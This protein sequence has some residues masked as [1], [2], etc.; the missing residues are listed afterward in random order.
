MIK[1]PKI[2]RIDQ[3]IGKIIFH[4]QGLFEKLKTCVVYTEK[5]G[6]K[7]QQKS[8]IMVFTLFFF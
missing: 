2:L 5:K 8:T 6:E 3:W 4:W 1:I 7:A